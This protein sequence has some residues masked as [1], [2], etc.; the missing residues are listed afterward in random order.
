MGKRFFRSAL[1]LLLLL[2]LLFTAAVGRRTCCSRSTSIQPKRLAPG[3]VASFRN[4][5]NSSSSGICSSGTPIT[6]SSSSRERIAAIRGGA[7]VTA[8]KSGSRRVESMAQQSPTSGLGRLRDAVFPIYGGEETGKFLA[9]GGI[10]FFIIFVLTLTRDLK[11]TLIITS[12]GAEAISFLKVYGVLPAAAVFMLGYSK[13]STMLSKRALFYVTALPF[14]VFYLFFKLIMYPMRASLHPSEAAVAALSGLP[15]GMSYV[16]NLYRY[17]TFALFYVVSELYSSVSIGVLFWQFA[18]DIVPVA[19]AKRFYPLFGQ[20]SSLAPVV[21]GLCVV[22]FTN[23]VSST[24][25]KGKG[26]TEGLLDFVL[27]L[28]MVAGGAIF[29]LYEVSTALSVREQKRLEAAGGG[30]VT[31]IAAKGKKPKLG[32]KESFRVLGKS[33]Y[34]GFLAT[35]VLGYGLCIAMTEVMWKSMVKRQYPAAVDYARF[36]GKYSSTLGMTTFVVIFFGSNLIKHVGWRAGALATPLSMALLAAPLFGV[37]IASKGD[38]GGTGLA[39]AVTVGTVQSVLSKATKYALFDPTTQMAYIPLD[40]ESKV[41]GKAAIDGLGSRLGKS[42][43]SFMQQGLVLGFGNI[44]NAAPVVAVIFYAALG[45]WTYG[46]VRLASMFETKTRE[47]DL[48][49]GSAAA[50]GTRGGSFDGSSGGWRSS[51]GAKDKKA[52]TND[53]GFP[54]YSFAR[55]AGSELV[56]RRALSRDSPA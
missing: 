30:P 9:L 25:G 35:L 13:V 16:V 29:A 8:K 38:L 48:R 11:D 52:E 21:A 12:C 53:A 20:M 26:V 1:L 22:R 46:A 2:L 42:G 40:E 45:S 51:A 34:L 56:H 43:A 14:F 37:V 27:N 50:V 5:N 55:S 3:T 33:K 6:I 41:K 49:S 18:N 28:V 32:L 24:G 4:I 10:Q 23:A 39:F 15:E 31:K 17:W 44:L 54:S 36:M 47:Q 19:Q 7:R